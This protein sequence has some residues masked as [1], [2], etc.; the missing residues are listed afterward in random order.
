MVQSKSCM[1]GCAGKTAR[2]LLIVF[3]IL[4]AVCG[5]T[6]LAV[7]IWLRVDPS[8]VQLQEL[9]NLDS[10]NPNLANAAYILIGFGGFMLLVSVFGCCGGIQKSR[11]LLGLY[12]A[13]LVII[14]IGQITAG[15]LA[16][17]YKTDVEHTIES[18]LLGVLENDY[19][20]GRTKYT[21]PWDYVQVWLHC[22]G[23]HNYTDYKDIKFGVGQMVPLT[24][25]ILENEDPNDPMPKNNTRCQLEANQTVA[26]EFLKPLGCLDGV[27][28]AIKEY[29]GILIGVAIGIAVIEILGILLACCVC[30]NIHS[31]KLA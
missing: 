2:V 17:L 6:I 28:N 7:G 25:C 24:C 1:A 19:K 15:I 26:G 3:N 8:V 30:K 13:C 4:F 14:F 22:C 9:V 21:Q 10:K 12:I 5:V 11:I 29:D 18:N 16:A 31:E 27:T 23:V 20:P